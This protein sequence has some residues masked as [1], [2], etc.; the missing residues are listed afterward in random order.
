MLRKQ[1]LETRR[2]RIA[3]ILQRGPATVDQLASRLRITT[4]AVRAQLT[5]MERDG[6]VRL[7]GLVPGT[8]RPAAVF[9]LTAAIEHLLSGAYI[10]LLTH[11]VG[12]FAGGLERQRFNELMRQT[13]RSLARDVGGGK[14]MIGD[15]QSRVRR[16]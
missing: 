14:R 6:L 3:E 13:G 10:P 11:M 8:T 1:F 2:G 15:L 7:A 4:S 16:A 9:E 12:T 5:T